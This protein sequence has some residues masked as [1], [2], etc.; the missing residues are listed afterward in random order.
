MEYIIKIDDNDN[1]NLFIDGVL[2]TQGPKPY[3]GDH[4]EYI[5]IREKVNISHCFAES[6]M[7]SV[8]LE[9]GVSVDAGDW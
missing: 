5:A 7:L 3:I 6:H 8:L 1:F 4:L 9:N 2:S